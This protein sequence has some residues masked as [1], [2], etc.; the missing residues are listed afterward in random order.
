[1]SSNEELYFPA[2]TDGLEQQ[3]V[4]VVACVAYLRTLVCDMKSS[5]SKLNIVQIIQEYN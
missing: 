3:A 5:I 1:M 2:D 4:V